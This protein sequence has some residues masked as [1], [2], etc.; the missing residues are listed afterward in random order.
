MFLLTNMITLPYFLFVTR[1]ELDNNG[2]QTLNKITNF[3]GFCYFLQI[4]EGHLHN[5]NVFVINSTF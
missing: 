5:W 2:L 4:C 3:K 1:I